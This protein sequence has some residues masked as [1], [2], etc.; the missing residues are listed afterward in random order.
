[1]LSQNNNQITI[2]VNKITSNIIES[3][4]ADVILKSFYILSFLHIVN[5]K[6]LTTFS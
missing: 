1:M 4:K 3:L 5:G 6:P 2:N